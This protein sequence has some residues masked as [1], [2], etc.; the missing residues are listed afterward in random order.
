MCSLFPS[1]LKSCLFLTFPFIFTTRMIIFSYYQNT[2]SSP[3]VTNHD[4]GSFWTCLSEDSQ[5][6]PQVRTLC[7]L[8]L[9]M[10]ACLIF[11]LLK[12]F[13][14]A[15]TQMLWV[16]GASTIAGL[17]GIQISIQRKETLSRLHWK[18]GK[19]LLKS[20]KWSNSHWSFEPLKMV[21]R[22][23]S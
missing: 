20:E 6:V 21:F 11:A 18:R 23:T 3:S 12:L 4:N 5:N 19:R 2:S 15:L 13:Y 10:T 16:F 9:D 14:K 7:S 8:L 22:T 1:E 17:I